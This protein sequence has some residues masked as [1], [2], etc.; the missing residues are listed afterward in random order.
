MTTRAYVPLPKYANVEIPKGGDIRASG[1][2]VYAPAVLA[3]MQ[4]GVGFGPLFIGVPKGGGCSLDRINFLPSDGDGGGFI[5]LGVAAGGGAVAAGRGPDQSDSEG[6]GATHTRR[7]ILGL[8]ASVLAAS[9]VGPAT[10]S[11]GTVALNIAEFELTDSTAPMRVR[12]LDAVDNVL[13]QTAEILVDAEESRVGEISSPSDGVILPGGTTGT[14]SV[15]LRDSRGN[16]SRL[17]AWAK[18]AFSPDETIEYSGTLPKKANKYSEGQFIKL[19]E[20]PA[21]IGPVEEHGH[22]KTAVNIGPATIPHQDTES[23]DAGS[24]G[25]FDGALVYEV[26]PAPPESDEWQMRTRLGRVEAW[27][28]RNL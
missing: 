2:K 22:E 23:S 27:R 12:V 17:L 4:T 3:C 18:G 8:A 15:Y 21:V 13:P 1:N 9:A 16:L 10:A 7:A 6:E 24:Y 20:H 26:G 25:V 28:E 14:V 19:S 5:T 11:D